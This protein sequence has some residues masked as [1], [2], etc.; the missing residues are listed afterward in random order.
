[1]VD[2][3][4]IEVHRMTGGVIAFQTGSNGTILNCTFIH[5]VASSGTAV[6]GS[7]NTN[8][9]I[10]GCLFC[11]NRVTAESNTSITIKILGGTVY[12]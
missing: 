12:C 7:P 10:F 8:M 1:M 6:Y 9:T 4:D 5:N 2:D 11:H 3:N